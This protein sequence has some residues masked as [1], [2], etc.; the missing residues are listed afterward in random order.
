MRRLTSPISQPR[1]DSPYQQCGLATQEIG[2]SE[3][4]HV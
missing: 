2:T 4:L 1:L 3:I